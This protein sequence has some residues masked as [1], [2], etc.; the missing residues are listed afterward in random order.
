[1][2][3]VDDCNVI[4]V[5]SVAD[6]TEWLRNLLSSTLKKNIQAKNTQQKVYEHQIL[7]SH[8]T[9]LAKDIEAELL[10]RGVSLRPSGRDGWQSGKCPFHHDVRPSFSISFELGAWKCWSGCGSGYLPSL[11]RRLGISNNRRSW[12]VRG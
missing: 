3:L 1:V 7:D 9:R 4:P 6:T 10:K 2:I 5:F 8:F 11:A 12:E